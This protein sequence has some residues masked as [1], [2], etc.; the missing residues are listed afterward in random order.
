MKSD[1]T[2]QSATAATSSQPKTPPSPGR[3]SPTPKTTRD[4]AAEGFSGTSSALPYQ[5]QMESGF[6]VSFSGVNVYAGGPAAA[7]NTAMGSE[8]Y[9]V[10]QNVA[11]KSSNPAPEIVAHELAHTLQ[12]GDAGPVQTWRDG[13]PGDAYEQEADAAAAAVVSGGT[14]SVSLKTGP[15]IQ[16]WGGSDHYTIGN[17]AGAK[18][19]ARFG[20]MFPGRSPDMPVVELPD[21]Q[22]RPGTPL[23]GGVLSGS[24]DG[25]ISQVPDNPN[26]GGNESRQTLGVSTDGGTISFGAASRY[27]GDYNTDVGSLAGRTDERGGVEAGGAR[28][29]FNTKR[30]F[31]QMSIG[32]MTNSNHFFPVNASEYM[33]HHQLAVAKAADAFRLGQEGNEAGARAA[34]AEASQEEGFA[35]HFLQDTF[36]SG[37]MAPRSLDSIGTLTGE[38]PSVIATTIDNA[39]NGVRSTARSIAS[40]P[41]QVIGGAVGAVGGFFGSLF[42]GGNVLEGAASGM[43]S[44][45]QTGGN[46]TGSVGEGVATVATAPAS[47][48]SSG[49]QGVS[50]L[51]QN[52]EATFSDASQGLMRSKQWHD[53]FCALPDGLPTTRGRFHGDYNM[54]GNDLEVVSETCADSIMEVLST[55]QGA[56][57]SYGMAGQI[58]QPD[59]GGIMADPAAGPV[60]RLM[61]Q[62]Y[63]DSL[64]AARAQVRE[65]DTHTTDGGTEVNSLDEVNQ[66][67][68]VVFGG[69]AGIA[70]A[71]AS[72]GAL[73]QVRGINSA[74]NEAA[75]DPTSINRRRTTLVET[76]R[77]A[78][79]YMNTTFGFNAN[80][81][82]NMDDELR[83][84]AASNADETG[85]DPVQ[86]ET[87]W[88]LYSNLAR[89]AREYQ[90][91]AAMAASTGGLADAERLRRETETATQI[92][93]A[94]DR[95][96][97][98]ARSEHGGVVEDARAAFS[99]GNVEEERAEFRADV[100]TSIHAWQTI[101][102]AGADFAVAAQNDQQAG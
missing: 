60:W 65:G 62:D 20:G 47:V 63:R 73:G 95:W 48:V 82:D 83:P 51:V 35:N 24:Q 57:A 89:V 40:A 13:S 100:N 52:A 2:T 27:G 79:H 93:E 71:D 31:A 77:G 56:P 68:D 49:V 84:H 18:A 8:A 9:A 76:L 102:T 4:M 34:M 33:N 15:S 66:I 37:H 21:D 50:N 88:G 1:Q 43:R 3:G 54:D 55:A 81:P 7:A 91:A 75:T 5:S 94:C 90:A 39:V 16:R 58:P 26:T 6:G 45:A 97:A 32:A 64:D 10:G 11:F 74:I 41:G 38:R 22:T 98:R 59:F 85:F 61:M 25:S 28:G 78:N 86:L 17:T 14:A 87:T 19:V 101:F 70:E 42:S 36:A 80:L 67:Y 30:E 72:Q 69:Q 46:I 96:A 44:G 99:H 23:G 29:E 53:Y 12:Q 92:A